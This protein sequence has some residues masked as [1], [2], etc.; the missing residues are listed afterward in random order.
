MVCREQGAEHL[1]LPFK[2]SVVK[3]TVEILY[4]APAACGGVAPAPAPEPLEQGQTPAAGSLSRAVAGSPAVAQAGR[5][6]RWSA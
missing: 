2:P 4:S 5:R 6:L 3:R 1:T